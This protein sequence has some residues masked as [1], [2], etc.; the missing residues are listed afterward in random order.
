MVAPWT[1]TP[2]ADHAVRPD[3]DGPAGV[4]VG[5]GVI[6]KAGVAAEQDALD[7]AAE[8]GAGPQV[9]ALLEHDVADDRRVRMDEG[10]GAEPG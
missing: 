5:D 8:H 9:G 3:D 7:V 2:V 6:L 10:A 1:M 4:G